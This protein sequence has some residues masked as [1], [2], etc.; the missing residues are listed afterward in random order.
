[1]LLWL[2]IVILPVALALIIAIGRARREERPVN[3]DQPQDTPTLRR[4]EPARS[5][6]P[7]G[8]QLGVRGFER[9]RASPG[10]WF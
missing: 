8:P 4:A 2:S 6:A 10:G 7:A 9:R 5:M 3:H 1:M